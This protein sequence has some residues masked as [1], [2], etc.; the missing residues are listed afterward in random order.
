MGRNASFIHL[1]FNLQD[2]EVSTVSTNYQAN[3]I[4]F[5]YTLQVTEAYC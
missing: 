5:Q 4:F 1:K 2:N 3:E